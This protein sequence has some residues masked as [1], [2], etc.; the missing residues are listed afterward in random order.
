[1][2]TKVYT[3]RKKYVRADGTINYCENKTK[4]IPVDKSVEKPKQVRKKKEGSINSLVDKLKA[5]DKESLERARKF[6]DELNGG[7]I[8]HNNLQGE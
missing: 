5:L 1:M 4:Y 8:R 3:Y 2:E 7:K 6:I